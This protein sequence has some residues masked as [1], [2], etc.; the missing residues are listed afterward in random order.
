MVLLHLRVH[1][2]GVDGFLRWLPRGIPFQGHSAFR[3]IAR[4]VGFY[5]GTHRTEILRDSGRFHRGVFVIVMGMVARRMGVR[6][7][8][9]A[10]RLRLGQK[11]PPAMLATKVKCLPVAFGTKS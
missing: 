2:A 4:L 11:P 10:S 3:A 6:T 5:A 8:S 9:A 1:R 7:A